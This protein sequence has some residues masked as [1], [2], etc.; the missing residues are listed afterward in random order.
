[1]QHQRDEDNNIHIRLV[2]SDHPLT[3]H[4]CDL[5]TIGRIYV[6]NSDVASFQ[7]LLISTANVVFGTEKNYLFH[8][9]CD[10]ARQ[11][12]SLSFKKII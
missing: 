8:V 11:S 2:G 1:M 4:V 9:S 5:D 7:E 3:M 12:F 6:P 10:R